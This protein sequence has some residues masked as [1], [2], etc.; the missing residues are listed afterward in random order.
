MSALTDALPPYFT[1]A[2]GEATAIFPRYPL[3]DLYPPLSTPIH[4]FFPRLN[5][6]R[7]YPR[8]GDLSDTLSRSD[9]GNPVGSDIRLL[10]HDLES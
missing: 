2:R 8:Y 3:T 10:F 7:G 5:D 6:M 1:R 9:N 4:R